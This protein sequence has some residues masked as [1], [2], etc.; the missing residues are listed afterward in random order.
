MSAIDGALIGT[1]PIGSPRIN[2]TNAIKKL[3]R[4]SATSSVKRFV[5][6][7]T[8]VT[9]AGVGGLQGQRLERGDMVSA[10]SNRAALGATSPA[11]GNCQ[12]IRAKPDGS[13]YGTFASVT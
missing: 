1:I 11:L 13:E 6:V 10:L 4:P 3:L 2:R 8:P 5:S 9:I 7:G 12:L